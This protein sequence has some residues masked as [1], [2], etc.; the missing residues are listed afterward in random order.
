[1]SDSKILDHPLTT[2]VGKA[3]AYL[4]NNFSP[5]SGFRSERK[6]STYLVDGE[7]EVREIASQIFHN[8]TLVLYIADNCNALE[9]FILYIGFIICMPSKFWRKVIYIVLGVILIDLINIF[10]CM[11]LI[12]LREYYHAYF[13]FAHHFL[14]KAIVYTFTLLIWMRFSRNINFKNSNESLQIG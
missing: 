13:D 5:M 6:L 10:R 4:L 9:L 8:D 7:L 11:G 12:Y 2:H 14:F 3:S 1:M